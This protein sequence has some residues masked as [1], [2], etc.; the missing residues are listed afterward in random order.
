M[1]R[2]SNLP[3]FLTIFLSTNPYVGPH[4]V[5]LLTQ[6]LRDL[7]PWISPYRLVCIHHST[8]FTDMWVEAVE[9][10]AHGVLLQVQSDLPTGALWALATN[11]SWGWTKCRPYNSN[12]TLYIV[13]HPDTAHSWRSMRFAVQLS[14]V[15]ELV[16][17]DTQE[18][19]YPGK[20]LMMRIP[21][22]SHL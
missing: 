9:T 8:L 14:N 10:V 22:G 7:T 15:R 18:V 19:T 20:Y 4:Y 6:P 11:L 16:P 3:I 5:T 1:L 21:T 13:E 12:I 17:K 2:F